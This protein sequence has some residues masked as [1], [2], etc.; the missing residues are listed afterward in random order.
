MEEKGETEGERGGKARAGAGLLLDPADI[1]DPINPIDPIDPIDPIASVAPAPPA[2]PS[3][4]VF[5]TDS[6]PDEGPD[7]R[8]APLA[9]SAALGF[10]PPEPGGALPSDFADR[11][12]VLHYPGALFANVEGV[13]RWTS[14]L[15]SSLSSPERSASLAGG[16]V[17]GASGRH[18]RHVFD[19]RDN[20]SAPASP[21]MSTCDGYDAHRGLRPGA[22]VFPGIDG[23]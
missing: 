10:D 9:S 23:S 21:N 11:L 7:P 12:P 18:S 16:R 20:L 4:H 3:E 13:P 22:R 19:T 17:G 14:A 5:L 15:P 6:E 2:T 8:P 1:I